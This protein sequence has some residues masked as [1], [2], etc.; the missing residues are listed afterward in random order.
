MPAGIL[1]GGS[2]ER[3]SQLGQGHELVNSTAEPRPNLCSK[4]SWPHVFCDND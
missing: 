3:Y 1:Q 2:P 4:I